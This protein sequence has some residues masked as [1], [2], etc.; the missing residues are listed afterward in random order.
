VNEPGTTI[1]VSHEAVALGA[2][3]GQH[4]TVHP[5]RGKHVGVVD[6]RELLGRER[7]GRSDHHVARVVDDHVDAAL[8]GEHCGHGAVHRRLIRDVHLDGPQR[9]VVLVGMMASRGS[10]VGIPATDVA[11]SPRRRRVRRLRGR[12]RSSRRIRS[13]HR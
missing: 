13:R 1:V 12:G 3:G 7:L 10:G 11:H 6:G 5:L 9:H 8:L 2:H 4:R